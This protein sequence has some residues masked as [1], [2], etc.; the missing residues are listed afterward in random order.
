MLRFEGIF[1]ASE[2]AA[3]ECWC[4]CWCLELHTWLLF[5]KQKLCVW[6]CCY[7]VNWMLNFYAIITCEHK[8]APC[9]V[10][11]IMQFA[12]NNAAMPMNILLS[13]WRYFLLF[14]FSM[15][16]VRL[17]FFFIVLFDCVL[18]FFYSTKRINS[19]KLNC[20]NVKTRRIR[21]F[22]S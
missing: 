8:C 5:F 7:F 12:P 21:S 22:C 1:F 20:W 3:V 14:Y 17:V 2:A 19:H 9:A 11:T 16:S 10:N 6:R 15:K 13:D 18:F 4:S